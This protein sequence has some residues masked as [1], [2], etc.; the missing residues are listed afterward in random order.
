M[1]LTKAR[2]FVFSVILILVSFGGGY[3][4]GISG[5]IANSKNFPKVIISREVPPEKELDF[6]LFWRVWD[7]LQASYLDKSKI[8][9]SEMVY[10][11]IKGMVA[12]VG[13]PYTVFLTPTENKV[14]E[15]DLQGNFDGVGIQIGFKGTRL[16]VIAPLPDSPAER[17]GVKPGDL[18]LG[19]KDEKK[20]IELATTG[21]SLPQ[22]VQI[23]R[24][25]KGTKVTLTLFREGLSEP[26]VVDLIRDTID[27]PS[28]TL[29]FV[30]ESEKVAHIKVLKFG[31]E[32]KQEWST[33]VKEILRQ[34]NLT[35]L[36]V[37]LRNN[38]GGYLQAAI[39]LASEFLP[40]GSTAVMEEKSNGQR[41]ELK[42]ESQGLLLNKKVVVLVNGGS[43]SA[44]EIL[45]GAL[46][47]LKGYKVVGETSF[48]KGTVQEPLTLDNGSGLHITIGKWL[49]PKGTWI[50]EKGIEPDIK[51]EDKDDTAEDEQLLEAIR[52]LSS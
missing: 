48:G 1:R 33:K 8:I 31:A 13:D 40:V 30:G 38:P 41:T 28:V 36:V 35:G 19:I 46:R 29:D 2:I 9:E 43:A 49:T 27:V 7:T 18:I 45:A 37:D 51:L 22:A 26:S 47:D 14:S 10:G 11:A 3:V 32:T 25:A 12:A 39:D 15:E 21:M 4:A 52:L 24:G 20:D 23:I 16:A 5:F 6:S 50:N 34:P 17:A 44:S 42:T